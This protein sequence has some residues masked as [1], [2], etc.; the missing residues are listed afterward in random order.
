MGIDIGADH[1]LRVAQLLPPNLLMAE[2]LIAP[3][4]QIE[5]LKSTVVLPFQ[6]VE[7]STIIAHYTPPRNPRT[8]VNL[9]NNAQHAEN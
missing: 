6:L 5:R 3:E 1:A 4:Q 2:F 8:H 9:S 7:F